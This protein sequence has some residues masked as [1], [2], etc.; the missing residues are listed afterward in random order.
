MRD[1]K[2][3]RPDVDIIHGKELRQETLG[4]LQCY[5]DHF[6]LSISVKN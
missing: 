6:N 1:P 4:G 3:A 5:T 2:I